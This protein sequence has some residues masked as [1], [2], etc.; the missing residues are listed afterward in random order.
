M[1]ALQPRV[2]A[3]QAKYAGDQERLQVHAA[4]A[5]LHVN[6][7]W[8]A[9]AQASAAKE[10]DA[11]P[12]Q[13]RHALSPGH[14]LCTSFPGRD[15]AKLF[16]N[17][18]AWP[19]DRFHTPAHVVLSCVLGCAL[20][21]ETAKLYQNAGVNPLAGCLPS[22]ATIPIFIGLY[23]CVG[24]P[25]PYVLSTD[26]VMSCCALLRSS[27]EVWQ[28]GHQPPSALTTVGALR[29]LLL[30]MHAGGH[31]PATGADCLRELLLTLLA[32]TRSAPPQRAVQCGGRGPADRGFLLD[33]LPGWAHHRQRE[34]CEGLSHGCGWHAVEGSRRL[35]ACLHPATGTLS[36]F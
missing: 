6:W 7:G 35:P 26:L 33:P 15:Q 28:A 30:R 19:G 22:L 16:H 36:V 23:R 17:G 14:F 32:L 9:E 31:R 5:K 3:L 34:H 1:Q 2:K 8:Q 27:R 18:S 13:G 29:P 25:S 24:K 11:V 12:Q 10:A 20:Q 4:A 21:V